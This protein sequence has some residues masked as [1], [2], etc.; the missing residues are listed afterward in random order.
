[1]PASSI[2]GKFLTGKVGIGDID[3]IHEWSVNETADRL[4]ATTGAD[5]G[6]GK[7]DV[8]V[9]DTRIRVVFYLG[10]ND[11]QYIFI[12]PGTTITNLNLWADQDATTALYAFTSAK[13]FDTTVRGQ[14]RDR[15]IVEADLEAYGDV[16]TATDPN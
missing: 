2:S 13:V 4:E 10:I 1:M 15:F 6:R 3:G 7:K 5:G 14:I 9:I 11:G 8:G 16:I 12:R